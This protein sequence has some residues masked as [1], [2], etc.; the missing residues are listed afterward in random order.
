MFSSA[1]VRVPKGNL[2]TFNKRIEN[3]QKKAKKLGGEVVCSPLS[4]NIEEHRIFVSHRDDRG[5]ITKT[6]KETKGFEIHTFGLTIIDLEIPGWSIVGSKN[7][8]EGIVFQIG[9]EKHNAGKDLVCEHC[10][11]NRRRNTTFILKSEEGEFKEIGST[12]INDY[13]GAVNAEKIAA[14][15]NSFLEEL[16]TIRENYDSFEWIGWDQTR[17]NQE[18]FLA[19]CFN[20]VSRNGWRSRWYNDGIYSERQY[21]T[22]D[23]VLDNILDERLDAKKIRPTLDDF[24]NVKNAISYIESLEEEECSVYEMNLKSACRFTSVSD[25]TAGIMASIIPYW[26]KK[27]ADLEKSNKET[28]HFG[29]LK[30]R[31]KDIHVRL[32][33]KKSGYSEYARFGDGSWRLYIFETVFPKQSGTREVLTCWSHNIVDDETTYSSALEINDYCVI[34]ATPVK[35]EDYN[36]E[37]QTNIN[38]VKGVRLANFKPSEP[39][40]EQTVLNTI[41]DDEKVELIEAFMNDR[42]GIEDEADGY[43]LDWFI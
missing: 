11:H 14:F 19:C 3:L 16:T 38:R 34:D 36:G 23:E 4:V 18:F 31:E 25:K 40:T 22:A 1:E 33:G 7:R 26:N 35:H 8:I 9:D 43:K 12:C 20:L 28:L 15:Y 30:K 39:I 6:F 17:I 10:H 13:T 37:K 41:S 21:G 2:K 5:G 24:W 29:T 32:I 27:K 42:R